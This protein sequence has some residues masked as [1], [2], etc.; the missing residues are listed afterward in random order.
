M[1]SPT[2]RK[3]LETSQIVEDTMIETERAA[4]RVFV[5]ETRM[6]QVGDILLD[7]WTS[8]LRNAQTSMPLSEAEFQ[9]RRRIM[10]HQ[11]QGDFYLFLILKLRSMVFICE[12]LIGDGMAVSNNVTNLH[13]YAVGVLKRG[14]NGTIRDIDD[15]K[16]VKAIDKVSIL[17]MNARSASSV[18]ALGSLLKN[19]NDKKKGIARIVYFASMAKVLERL[20]GLQLVLERTARLIMRARCVH[21][22]TQMY[23]KL[24]K[25]GRFLVLVLGYQDDVPQ[26]EGAQLAAT[27]ITRHL[28]HPKKGSPL[29]KMMKSKKGELPKDALPEMIVSLTL[30]LSIKEIQALPPVKYEMGEC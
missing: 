7:R 18:R 26:R 13:N 29:Y 21:K 17:E 25:L 16:L 15:R 24:K 30:G 2:E 3:L 28:M 22:G 27:L 19:D 1:L 4:A 20:C 5:Y 6:Q 12:T 11:D 23:N 10:L 9:E 14:V 8:E